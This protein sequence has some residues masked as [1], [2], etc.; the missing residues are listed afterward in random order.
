M[1]IRQQIEPAGTS[2]GHGWLEGLAASSKEAEAQRLKEEMKGLAEKS[3]WAGVER[4][5]QQWSKLKAAADYEVYDL[6]EHAASYLGCGIARYL[7]TIK[8]LEASTAPGTHPAAFSRH[9]AA[10]QF[11]ERT[12]A[13]VDIRLSR[14]ARGDLQT[15]G[16]L[17]RGLYPGAYEMSTIK[18]AREELKATR[19]FDGLLPAVPYTIDGHTVPLGPG[20]AISSGV[21][22][23]NIDQ[24]GDGSF[25]LQPK[26]G[27]WNYL[28]GS[29]EC[30]L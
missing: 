5:Y 29:D 24:K 23:V 10:K 11:M 8:A 7:R 15:D 26:P 21:S 12:Y 13:H 16:S 22:V 1:Y 3:L 20:F 9:T 14:S 30:P 28:R 17:P 4:T 25:Q 19:K 18:R 2:L 6:A 27:R